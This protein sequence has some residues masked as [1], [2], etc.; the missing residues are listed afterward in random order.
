MI[1]PAKELEA[2]RPVW[3]ALADMFLDTDVSIT[4][5]WRARVLAASKYTVPELEKILAEE[6]YPI[7]WPNLLSVAG[8]W[9]GF[10]PEWLE[11]K[12]LSRSRRFTIW[13]IL[14][15]AP[16]AIPI[17]REWRATKTAIAVIKS[18]QSE[19]AV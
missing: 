16:L 2:R 12:I 14:N 6:I 1:D 11:A 9:S 3:S 7:C 15:I 5:E 19:N 18:K 10:D 13:Q 8:E 17:A 4:R